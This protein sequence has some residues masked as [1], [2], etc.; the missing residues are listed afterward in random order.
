METPKFELQPYFNLAWRRKWSI[1]IPAIVVFALGAAYAK[2]C[3]KLYKASSR[4]LVQPQAIP[5]SFIRSTVTE[6]V[7]SRLGAIKQEIHSRNN[8]EKLIKEFNLTRGKLDMQQELFEL[9][10][11]TLRKVGLGRFASLFASSDPTL[12]TLA[13]IEDLRKQITVS[14]MS[15]GKRDEGIV[16]FEIE[17]VW[18]DPTVVAPLT[19]AVASRFIDANLNVRQQIALSTT[20]FLDKETENIRKELEAR[21]KELQDFKAQHMGT[22]PEQLESNI[23]ILSQMREEQSALQAK[24]FQEKQQSMLLRST[25]ARS[26]EE[27]RSNPE[28]L[29]A[30][31][32]KE[33]EAKLQSLSLK[34]T[35][36]HPDIIALKREIAIRKESGGDQAE[37]PA[38][39]DDF[40][41][42]ELRRSSE[43][44]ASYEKS[45]QELDKQIGLYKQRVE[46]T[47]R[48]EMAMTQI[49]RDYETVRQKYQA[50]LAK[51]LDAK[52]AEEMERRQQAEQFK[53]LDKA[54]PPEKP[55]KPDIVR[56]LLMTLAAGLGAGFGLAYLREMLDS[57][58]YNPA[59]VA[60]YLDTKVLVSLPPI[61]RDLKQLK[62]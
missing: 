26:R 28:E 43:R 62:N 8:L 3:P 38:K 17:F 55:F 44:I 11:K 48:V 36:K 10:E 31:S 42:M 9:L 14:T 61:E 2:V 24:I 22:L 19:N 1:I 54:I 25:P 16:V 46:E 47:P 33:L 59:D 30:G 58:F 4:I 5:E 53:I 35:E 29:T 7:E 23:N 13:L 57:R 6:S 40:Q 12:P 34:Y 39:V 41:G 51:K 20:D 45:L 18:N 32:L 60:S 56:I 21:E 37:E 49:M 27:N 15:A 50:M 52:M